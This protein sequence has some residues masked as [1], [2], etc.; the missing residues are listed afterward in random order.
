MS[1]WYYADRQRHQHGPLPA[2]ELARLHAAGTVDAA[3]LVWREGMEAWRP[4]GALRAELGLEEAPA[5]LDFRAGP[6]APAPVTAPVAG[7]HARPPEAHYA[8]PAGT[9]TDGGYR[10]HAGAVA[11]SGAV[12]TSFNAGE[13]VHAG[14]W[15]RFAASCI[16]GLVTGVVGYALLIPLM[17]AYGVSMSSFAQAELAGSGMNL[18]FMLFYYAISFGVP[19][20][21]FAWMHSSSSQASL[22]KMA[23]GARV[24]RGDG[25]P[26]GFGRAFLR[27]LAYF[28]FVVLT[29]GIGVLV[30]GLMVA[31]TERKQAPHDMVCDTLVVDKWAFTDHPE[32]QQQGLGTV[33]VVVLVLFGLFLLGILALG[34]AMVAMI[35]SMG[36]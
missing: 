10:R 30:S 2:S 35:G 3:T 21:Y 14:L 6:E 4:L 19:A 5:T 23:V 26:I 12:A 28:L 8:P 33:T 20:L 9:S 31:F 24:V 29:C 7:G 18:G 16:D 17:L 22:G 32:R 1:Q 36:F 34:L 13:V 11:A 15:R 27:Y 25:S